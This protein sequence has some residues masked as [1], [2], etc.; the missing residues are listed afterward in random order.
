VG[1]SWFGKYLATLTSSINK[2]GDDSNPRGIISAA[3]S[4]YRAVKLAAI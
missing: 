2:H 4:Q 3:G 1:A